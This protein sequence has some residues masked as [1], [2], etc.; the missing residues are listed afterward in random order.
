M[1]CALDDDGNKASADPAIRLEHELG[2]RRA[3]RGLGVCLPYEI[4]ETPSD[5]SV[6]VPLE[7]LEQV[8]VVTEDSVGSCIDPRLS[9]SP[10]ETPRSR[11]SL[12]PP[13]A[14]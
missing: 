2:D 4:S 3:F 14:L 13:S 6:V 5:R 8:L 9:L 12:L 7:G 10:F 11:G 1:A